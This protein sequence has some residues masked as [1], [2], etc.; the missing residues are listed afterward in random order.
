MRTFHTHIL[1]VLLHCW[2]CLAHLLAY[3]CVKT[4]WVLPFETQGKILRTLKLTFF[5][6]KPNTYPRF[7]LSFSCQVKQISSNLIYEFKFLFLFFSFMKV[8]IIKSIQ[9]E[10]CP[11][12]D[13][14]ILKIFIFWNLYIVI[15]HL[16][17]V[18]FECFMHISTYLMCLW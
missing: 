5:F 16:V 12:N 9:C 6:T 4:Y 2:A 15:G 3:K 7:S 14:Q 17:F 18:T 13:P 8:R 11:I 10:L 1:W